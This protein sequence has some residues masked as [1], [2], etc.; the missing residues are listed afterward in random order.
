MNQLLNNHRYCALFCLGCISALGMAPVYAWP[1][2]F[3]GYIVLMFFLVKSGGNKKPALCAFLFFFGYYLTSFY[4]VSSSLFIDLNQWW[5]ALP[6]SFIGLPLLLSL[7][8][9]FFTYLASFSPKYKWACYTTALIAADW[10]RGTLFTG[11]PWNFPAH[12]WVH[13]DTVM[14]L[15]PYIGLYGLNAVTITLFFL[16]ALLSKWVKITFFV[17]AVVSITLIPINKVN[18]EFPLGNNITLVQANISQGEKWDP[19]YMWRN[20]DRYLSMSQSLNKRTDAQIIIW[21]ETALS[22]QFL[23]YPEPKAE[24]LKFLKEL[25]IN[26]ILISGYLNHENGHPINSLVA[27]NTRG[28]IIARYNKHHLVPFGEYMPFGLETVTGFSNFKNGIKPEPIT[29]SHIGLTFLPL[30]CYEII[31]PQYSQAAKNADFILNITNDAWFG[32]TAGP[33]QHFDHAIIRAIE[34][35]KAVIR[36]SGNG[37]SA[38]INPHGDVMSSSLLNKQST[39][40][41]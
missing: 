18:V 40:I 13:T 17:A 19:Q 6:L 41:Y 23:S 5:W 2:M 22:E 9:V 4:W 28:D 34:N 16:P 12:T 15:L 37:I 20:F 32:K 8:P 10:A 1:L 26:S 30:I 24:F 11:F 38:I 27:F 21:P 31:F 35:K 25:P 29:I 36:I 7:F 14:A 3:V 39:I 33:Y